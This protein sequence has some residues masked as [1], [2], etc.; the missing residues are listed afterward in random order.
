[1]N[2]HFMMRRDFFLKNV[3]KIE[4]HLT[5]HYFIKYCCLEKNGDISITNN[6]YN[7]TIFWNIWISIYNSQP[8]NI[9][10]YKKKER[11]ILYSTPVKTLQ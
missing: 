5:N 7:I 9:T 8:D 2:F 11:Q 6:L 1:M 4:N 3:K 10:F